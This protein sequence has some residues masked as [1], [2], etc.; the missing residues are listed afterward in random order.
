MRKKCERNG[1]RDKG[2]EG[3]TNKKNFA[4]GNKEA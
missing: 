4:E 2:D 1:G 3:E